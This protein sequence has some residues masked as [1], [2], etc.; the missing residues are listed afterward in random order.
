MKREPSPCNPYKRKAK[1]K[2]IK[3][4]ALG[5]CL[6]RATRVRA[7]VSAAVEDALVAFHGTRGRA[8]SDEA[9]WAEFA[10]R[11]GYGALLEAVY[12]GESEL[13]EHETPIPDTDK[14]KVLQAILNRKWQAGGAR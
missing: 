2:E 11:F 14:P 1:G 3:P 4:G 13:S 8:P 10:W 5:T 7:H 6:S 9:L 12:Q